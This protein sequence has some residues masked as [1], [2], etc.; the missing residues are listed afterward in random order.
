MATGSSAPLREMWYYAVAGERLRPGRTMPKTMLGEHLLLGRTAD[1][2]VFAL[3]DVCPHRGIPLRFGQFDGQEVECRFHGWRFDRGGR[4][5]AIPSL[6]SEQKLDIGKIKVKAYPAREVQG[7]VWVYF[8]DEPKGA[9]EIPVLPEVGE[10]MP[11]LIETLAANC[12]IDEAVFGQMDPTHNPFVHVS[13]WWR[14]PGSIKEKAKAFAA[15]PWGFTML[16]HEP[17][18]NL[19]AYRLLGKPVTQIFFRLPSTR[20]EHIRIGKHWI[21]TLNAVTPIND[22]Q[23]EMNYAAYWNIG[24]IKPFLPVFHY[25]L[26]TFI[27]QDRRI[28]EM[29]TEGLKDDPSLMLVNDAD[30]QAKW[31]FRLKAEYARARDEGRPFVNPVKDRVLHWR[32]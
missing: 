9:P 2:E 11:G 20:I 18:D 4:C 21:V 32:S 19:S 8:G 5:T 14:R 24:W 1:G 23:I 25:A 12:A 6:T 29:Q 15:A 10:R 27:N 16:P 31:Y 13:W 3:K 30:I 26:R 7:N 22:T 28:L 17:S